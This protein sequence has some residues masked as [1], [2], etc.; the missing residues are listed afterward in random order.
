MLNMLNR[1]IHVNDGFD[2]SN[3]MSGLWG[4]G[5]GTWKTANIFEDVELQALLDED[6]SQ[7]QKQLALRAI[8]R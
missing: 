8:G 5:Q 3:V 7:T 4:C 2:V 1:K 6:V